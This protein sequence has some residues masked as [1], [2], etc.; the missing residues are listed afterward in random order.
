MENIRVIKCGNCSNLL[1]DIW[2]ALK[3]RCKIICEGERLRKISI[4]FYSY[5]IPPF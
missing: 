5:K 2:D 3:V 4:G 1:F